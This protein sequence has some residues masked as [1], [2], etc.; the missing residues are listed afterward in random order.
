MGRQAF[1]RRGGGCEWVTG[2]GGGQRGSRA[3]SY[4]T[5]VVAAGRRIGQKSPGGF[6]PPKMVLYWEGRFPILSS[7]WCQIAP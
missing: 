4:V 5:F 3:F 6:L 7:Q 1:M 2:G